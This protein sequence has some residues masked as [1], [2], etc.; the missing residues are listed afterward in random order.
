MCGVLAVAS[1]SPTDWTDVAGAMSDVLTYCG[2]DT[3]GL[4][5]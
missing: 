2:P 4:P 1:F 5:S 3:A